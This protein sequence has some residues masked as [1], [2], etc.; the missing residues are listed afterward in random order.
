M[1]TGII[2]RVG[3][4]RSVSREPGD[5][6]R[7]G[8]YAPE[9]AAELKLG[10]SVSVSGACLTAVETS[11]SIFQAQMM[12][13]TLRST[14]LG[15]LSSGDKVNLELSLRA[16]GRLGGHIVLGHVDEAGRVK[17]IEKAGSARKLWIAVSEGI[18]WGIA[19]KGSVTLDGVSLTV[20]DSQGGIFS[21]GLIPATLRE[22]TMGFLKE[23]DQVNVEIDVIA[24][25][26]AKLLGYRGLSV[27][28]EELDNAGSAGEKKLTWEKLGK[29][30]WT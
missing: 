10:E 26:M 19:A 16:G 11:G 7:V 6:W 9:I 29:Y 24:R 12:K 28:P 21:V 2:E 30:G 5:I 27:L 25:Y 15:G 4:V 23:G 22:T 1:F 8:I 14:W 17:K 13:E 20:I 3:V 18:S